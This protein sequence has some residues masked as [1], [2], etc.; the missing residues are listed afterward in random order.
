MIAARR[1]AVS[2]I[3]I[4]SAAVFI[5]IGDSQITRA[6]DF[7]SCSLPYGAI[8]L[9]GGFSGLSKCN[10][11][12]FQAKEVGKI[13]ISGNTYSILDYRYRTGPNSN[14]GAH[15]GQRILVVED[16]RNYMGEY[17]VGTPPF[18]TVTVRGASVFIDGPQK[19]GNEIRFDK[20]GPP[21]QA[22]LAGDLVSLLK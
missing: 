14:G 2:L 15:G 1:I 13:A 6:D 16:G 17:V 10:T 21:H 5:V 4:L 7:K 18:F 8:L 22:Y 11:G 19:Y 3:Q 12:T 9:E 20:D